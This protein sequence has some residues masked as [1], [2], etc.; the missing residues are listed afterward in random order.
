MTE[1]T[2]ADGLDLSTR[3]VVVTGGAG[4]LGSFVLEGLRARGV[5]HVF[6][7]RSAE[8]DLRDRAAIQR[9]LDI[10]RPDI[11]I[12]M[13]AVVGGIGANAILAPTALQHRRRSRRRQRRRR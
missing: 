1:S 10:A 8:F 7:P 5:E 4:F 12:H 13:A 11:I 2:Q 6:V 3:R 9:M